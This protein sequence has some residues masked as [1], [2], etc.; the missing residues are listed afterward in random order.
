MKIAI[1]GHGRCGK[2]TV[3]EFLAETPWFKYVAGTSWWARHLV[4]SK[5]PPCVYADAKACW[6]DRHNHRAAWANIIGEYNQKDPVALYRDCLAE[7]NVLTGIRWR[8]EMQ[9]CRAAKLVDLWLWVERPGIPS[10]PTQEF[11]ASECDLVLLNDG[12]VDAL[13]KK[14]MTIA[15]VIG[16]GFVSS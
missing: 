15:Q 6:M 16:Q 9:A 1:S 13:H 8:R 11:T 4:F 3:A 7:Q 14:V 2:D 5:M 12:D 10:D